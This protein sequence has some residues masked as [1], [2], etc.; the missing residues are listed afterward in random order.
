ME[1][2]V[3]RTREPFTIINEK[4]EVLIHAS[5]M[6][7]E[8][9]RCYVKDLG[10]HILE[11]LDGCYEAYRILSGIVDAINGRGEKR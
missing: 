4:V 9:F 5:P 7:W 1:I 8:G 10:E 2:K 3:V 6:E 11:D